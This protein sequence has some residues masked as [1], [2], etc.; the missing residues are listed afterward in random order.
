MEGEKRREKEEQEIENKKT[1]P[2]WVPRWTIL[3]ASL[4]YF[5]KNL[6]RIV[7][8]YIKKYTLENRVYSLL[9]PMPKVNK[10]SV[11]TGVSQHFT[12]RPSGRQLFTHNKGSAVGEAESSPPVSLIA[13]SA[14][15]YTG[16]K[17]T[18]VGTFTF[19]WEKGNL[20]LAYVMKVPKRWTLLLLFFFSVPLILSQCFGFF[21]TGNSTFLHGTC[22]VL[23]HEKFCSPYVNSFWQK[24]NHFIRKPLIKL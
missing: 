5:F 17:I 24:K 2:E 16:L 3:L 19:D 7:Q 18:S 8:F 13:S 14:T 4:A 20:K 22:L 10:Y 6:F 23:F 1:C 21:L 12:L 11:A 9:D 15:W